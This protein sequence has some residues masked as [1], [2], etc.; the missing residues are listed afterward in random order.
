MDVDVGDGLRLHVAASGNGP[1]VVLL[2]GFT[3]STDTWNFLRPLLDERYRAVAVD[4]PGHGR[5]LSPPEA[6]RYSLDRFA[7]D[8]A[9]V[10]AA[11]DIERAA[12]LGY[13]LGGRAA[14]RFA[15]A[16]PHRTAGLILESTSPGISDPLERAARVKSDALLA[17]LIERDGVEAFVS[18]WE[19]LP[20]WESQ[21]TLPD[22]GRQALRDQRLSSDARGLANSLRGAGAGAD[23]NVLDESAAISVPA[24]V[25]AG[26]LDTRYVDLGRRL[27]RSIPR[28]ELQIIA[29][30][31]H[32]THLEQPEVFAGLVA[33]FLAKI[34]AA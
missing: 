8:L 21:R 25:I 2:H 19:K 26:E 18:R 22:A 16:Q 23:A 6:S 7:A 4:L 13:S 27:A 20:L 15:I 29:D 28:A 14:I 30:S 34:Q 17:D 1:A 24:L 12:V 10:L 33:A 9:C 31:G 3:G 5:S 11:L 32:A